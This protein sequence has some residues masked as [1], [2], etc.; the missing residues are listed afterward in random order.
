M[1]KL[2]ELRLIKRLYSLKKAEAKKRGKDW[3]IDL[4]LFRILVK[5]PCTYCG[6]IESNEMLYLGESL[7]YNG[8]DRLDT[9]GDYT[10]TNS[11]P[12]CRFC[13][14]L[15]GSITFTQWAEFID[16]VGEIA[17]GR[18]Q[19]KTRRGSSGYEKISY[20]KR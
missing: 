3:K 5:A 10:I 18:R 7:K 4:A 9:K 1:I 16:N 19:F 20:Y 14:S 12:C 15:R 8:I 11:V 2:V 13:N 6:S 17:N